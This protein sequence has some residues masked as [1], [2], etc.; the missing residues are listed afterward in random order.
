MQVKS[1]DHIH[2]YSAD[3]A[4]SVAFFSRHFGAQKVFETK[5]AHHQDVHIL[6]VGGQGV[7][8]S[9]Y[10]PGT[11]P[12]RSGLDDAEARDGVAPAAGVM[13]LGFNV[14]DVAAAV[15]EL[16]E[17]GVRVH[18]EPDEAYG[19]TFAYVSTPD[20]VLIELTQY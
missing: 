3:P 19:T 9:A 14:E 5:N 11:A 4:A 20:G 18:T 16:R 2:I 17:A 7:A 6:Q 15:R 10:P 13:H 12:K 1:I 8:L